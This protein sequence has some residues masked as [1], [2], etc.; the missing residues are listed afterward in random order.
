MKDHYRTLGLLPT[1]TNEEIKKSYRRLAQ[2][3][4][5]D[6]SGHT[7]AA[8]L[9]HQIQE[10]YSILS[11]AKK[12]QQYDEARYFSKASTI[13]T[14]QPYSANDVLAL[15][16]NLNE[17]TQNLSAYD[18][19]HQLLY[20][21]A[22]WILAEDHIAYLQH[23]DNIANKKQFVIWMI[24]AIQKLDFRYFKIITERLIAIAENEATILQTIN[25]TALKRKKESHIKQWTPFLIVS[26]VL[27]L[28]VLMYW[29]GKK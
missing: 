24:T 18:I 12:K 5:P 26:M 6:K 14:A 20:E 7:T 22:L 4:H 19:N 28:C 13:K 17:R 8:H 3:Y 16:K 9:F 23:E 25:Q 2:Q 27:V 29:Y 10:A 1:A 15:A 11:D 21:Y